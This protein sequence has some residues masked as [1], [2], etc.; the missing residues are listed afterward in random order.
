MCSDIGNYTYRG[1]HSIMYR[2]INSY[3][4]PATNITMYVNQT[5]PK[6]KQETHE[7]NLKIKINKKQQRYVQRYNV[8]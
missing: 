6:Y 3:D 1:E 2:T 7:S 8:Q 5:S 4:I